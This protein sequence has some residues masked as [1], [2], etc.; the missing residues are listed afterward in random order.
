MSSSYLENNL[1]GQV[2]RLM[3]VIP[4]LWEANL[5]KGGSHIEMNSFHSHI[6][7]HEGTVSGD[8]DTEEMTGVCL[9]ESKSLN[10]FSNAKR[11]FSRAVIAKSLFFFETEPYTVA[12]AGVQ[13]R[14]LSSLQPPPPRFKQFSC[15]S[16]PRSWDYRRPSPCLANFLYFLVETEFHHTESRFVAHAVVQWCSGAVVRSQLTAASTSREQLLFEHMTHYNLLP[17]LAKASPPRAHLQL[18]SVSEHRRVHGNNSHGAACFMS[19]QIFEQWVVL[20][21]END[22]FGNGM[23]VTAASEASRVDRDKRLSFPCR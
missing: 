4:A 14:D 1:E 15:L 13:R 8:S 10:M 3:L 22:S 11:D 20:T 12:Q 2:R 5:A 6:I 17:C 21:A 18:P 7:E 9:E 23:L 19:E 16:L